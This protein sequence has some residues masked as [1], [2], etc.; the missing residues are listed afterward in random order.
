MGGPQHEESNMSKEKVVG[1]LRYSRYQYRMGLGIFVGCVI[2]ALG[3]SL[4]FF[5]NLWTNPLFIPV[6]LGCLAFVFFIVFFYVKFLEKNVLVLTDSTLTFERPKMNPE[7]HTY[8]DIKKARLVR[9]GAHLVLHLSFVDGG[10][11]KTDVNKEVLRWL[12]SH[13]VEVEAPSR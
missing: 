9:D 7:V 11:W 6:L 3:I 8:G 4:G 1:E 2:G 13:H 10:R 5:F 12:Q